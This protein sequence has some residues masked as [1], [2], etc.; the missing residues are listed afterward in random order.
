MGIFPERVWFCVWWKD[1]LCVFFGL[2]W[3]I[4]SV[5]YIGIVFWN[6][7]Q[8]SIF[9]KGCNTFC[10]L[11]DIL[12]IVSESFLLVMVFLTWVPNFNTIIYKLRVGVPF[13]LL[14]SWFCL[15]VLLYASSFPYLFPSL[16]KFLALTKRCLDLYWNLGFM[17]KFSMV[18]TN[19][20]EYELYPCCGP[21]VFKVFC[22]CLFSAVAFSSNSTWNDI[23]SL[24][25][26]R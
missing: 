17:L 13:N 16:K 11:L 14:S 2:C 9:L 18:C 15:F 12:Y 20:S 4:L 21:R 8:T 26:D 3:F 22:C 7:M 6:S 5:W 10:T 19:P 25:M 24:L 1:V 23:R